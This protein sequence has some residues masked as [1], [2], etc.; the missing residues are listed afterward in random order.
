MCIRPQQQRGGARGSGI[1][2]KLLNPVELFCEI[3]EVDKSTMT[4]YKIPNVVNHLVNGRVLS[5]RRLPLMQTTL[6]IFCLSFLPQVPA[7]ANWPQFRGPQ[8]GVNSTSDLPVLWGDE[9]IAWKTELPGPG[10]SSPVTY[11]EHIY[12]TCYTGYGVESE[13]P[14]DP[15]DLERHVLCINSSNGQIIWMVTIGAKSSE[16]EFTDWA[17]ALHGYSSSTPTV[18]SNSVY[19]F[20]GDAGCIAFDHSGQRKWTFDCGS[21]THLFGSG[22][23]PVLYNDLVIVNASPEIGDLIAI[24]KSSGR[25]VW[26]QSGIQKSWNTPAIYQNTN[27]SNELAISIEGEIL[28]FKPEDGTLLWRCQAIKDYICPS[29]VVQDGTLY[30]L[31]GRK[32]KT[33]AVRSGG[34]EDVT[35]THKLWELEKGSNVSS[36]VIHGR[37]IFWA[38]E[39]GIVYCANIDSGKLVYE[40]RLKPS[41]GLIYASPLLSGGNLYYVSRENGTYVVAAKPEYKL[42][43]HNVIQGDE[44][45]FNASPVPSGNGLLLRSDKYLLHI[46]D[47]STK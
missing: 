11:G 10:A 37:H 33:V 17:V 12:L 13:N 47:N 21:R 35:E 1:R 24:S 7:A 43:A 27:G 30:A 42:V 15:S 23:S 26:R 6:T 31:G 28:G 41:S 46:R 40:Q 34:F 4:S 8:F 2:T 38:R 14:G 22:A 45:V 3:G 39:K 32:N 9:N 29:I 5:M 18:D 36:P 16:N 44:S 25:E 19:V 20:L